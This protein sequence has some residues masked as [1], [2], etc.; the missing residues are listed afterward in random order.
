MSIKSN[1]YTVCVMPESGGAAR[2]F[3]ISIKAVTF[4]AVFFLC[5]LGAL[6]ALS[7]DYYNKLNLNKKVKSLQAL[8]EKQNSEIRLQRTQIQKSA[9]DLDSLNQSLA[10]LQEFGK[11][12]GALASW[13]GDE[14]STGL[15]AMGGSL[16]DNI[17]PSIPTEARHTGLAREMNNQAVEL[18]AVTTNME[19]SYGSLYQYLEEKKDILACTPSIKPFKDGWYTSRFGYRK[20]PF[21]GLRE[22]HKGIDVGAAKGTPVLAP[23]NGRVIFSGKNGGFGITIVVDHGHGY[24]TR[25]AHLQKTLKKKGERVKRGETIALVGN[26]GRSTGPHL[27]YEVHLNGIPVNPRRYILN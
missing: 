18:A 3:Q 1:R 4:A 10:R 9:K 15:M 26:T 25:Y 20:S 19:K 8:V 11:K 13:G 7:Y 21:T 14:D 17:E 22:F 16:P 5:I 2:Q 12:V 27:H 24:K 6:G 23:A